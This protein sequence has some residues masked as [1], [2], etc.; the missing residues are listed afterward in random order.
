MDKKIVKRLLLVLGI[1]LCSLSLMIS[2]FMSITDFV[3]GLI[4]GIGI[5]L[6]ILALLV[7]VPFHKNNIS[8]KQ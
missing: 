4:Q 1:I 5:G 6:M 8:R 7:Q 2:H 3:K